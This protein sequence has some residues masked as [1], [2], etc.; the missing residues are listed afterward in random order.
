MGLDPFMAWIRS[1][2]VE[3]CV[4]RWAPGVCHPDLT[5]WGSDL[6]MGQVP[7]THPAFS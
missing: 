2:Q 4:V 1:T 5:A 6:S 3:L 7:E